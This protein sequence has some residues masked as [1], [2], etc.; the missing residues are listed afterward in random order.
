M[1]KNEIGERE[2]FCLALRG[3]MYI[4]KPTE[5]IV[6]DLP[7]T[8]GFNGGSYIVMNDGDHLSVLPN[9]DNHPVGAMLWMH[10]S[11]EEVDLARRI[12]AA[13]GNN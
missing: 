7:T 2:T 4:L 6:V 10:D 9:E 13:L 1:G 11:Q 12:D 8:N 3:L 5:A